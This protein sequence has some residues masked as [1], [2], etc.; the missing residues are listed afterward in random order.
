MKATKSIVI[1]ADKSPN[2]YKIGQENY[3]KLL[4]ENVTKEYK[5]ESGAELKN[6]N[7][8]TA[9]IAKSLDLEEKMH[10]H[11]NTQCYITLK[12]HKKNF[13]STQ[14]CRLINPAKTDIGR[15]SKIK[16]QE[17][18]R[19]VRMKT[20]LM[21]WQSTQ[22]VLKWFKELKLERKTRTKYKFLKFDVEAF[23]PSITRNL[24]LKALEF[25]R[26][27]TTF[28]TQDKNIILQARETYL[29]HKNEPWSKKNN[30]DKFDVPMG[31]YDGA[32][33]CE[34]VGLYLLD[35]LTEKN[36]PFEN[37][38]N[39]V[40]LY[41]DDGLAVVKGTGQMIEKLTQKIRK[42]FG[43]N[44]LKITV[45]ANIH[46]TDFLDIS[47]NLNTHEHRPFRKENSYPLYINVGS[48][49]PKTI[50][51]QIPTMVERRLSELSCSEKVFEEQKVEYERALKEA[52]HRHHLE[53][54]GYEK[55]EKKKK[56]RTRN[57]I[58]FNPPYSLNVK[59]NVGKIFLKI[60]DKHFPKKSKL[61]KFFNRSKIKVS[62]RTMPNIK[63]HISKHNA[64]IS[65]D[66][67][68][69]KNKE[70]KMFR[71]KLKNCNCNN[72]QNCPLRGNCQEE[73]VV[74]QAKV[75]VPE[76]NEEKFYYGMTSGTFKSRY[77]GH[78]N[79]FKYDKKESTTLSSYIWKQKNAGR[80]FDIEWSIKA[81][82]Y[83]FSSGS[84]QCDLCLTEKL[85]ILLSDQETMLNKRDEILNKCPHRRKYCL[86]ALK[87]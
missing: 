10:Q 21:Q 84:K 19:E 26:K 77:S 72:P 76:I 83:A 29:F 52:G 44:E 64:K 82:A 36:A 25:A 18:N 74:Y 34:L 39:E 4:A 63:N 58:Y 54:K 22:E 48:N 80:K 5:K 40:G 56:K 23:Y 9:E 14:P 11:T 78:K 31:S 12:D 57:P 2:F 55:R 32:E 70:G 47:M 6:T 27:T 69:M 41:R 81:K 15:V 7:E 61:N 3:E 24:L 85:T 45:E 17:I 49:H 65:K 20:K 66:K 37:K 75:L 33:V 71:N 67:D 28:T 38:K 59:T 87:T 73:S 1:G 30:Q 68:N 42:I 16:L 62:Y 60:V 50:I 51:E 8:K 53:Y 43:D 79:S 46:E 35:R 13:M 86:K